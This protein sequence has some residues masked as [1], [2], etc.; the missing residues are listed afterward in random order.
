MNVLPETI[1]EGHASRYEPDDLSIGHASR[2]EPLISNESLSNIMNM[3]AETIF[4]GYAS[5][6]GPRRQIKKY[7]TERKSR[8]NK[9][10]R[11]IRLMKA[12]MKVHEENCDS[13]DLMLKINKKQ[14]SI[15]NPSYL[16]MCVL[17]EGFSI[18]IYI[19]TYD[20]EMWNG[21]VHMKHAVRLILEKGMVAMCHESLDHFGTK[22]R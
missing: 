2:Q 4:D 9:N 13:N 5:R 20:T 22:S 15:P 6:H 3:L 18:I 14:E 7:Q 17:E 8:K 12:V 16:M 11:V 10:M 1:F 19:C 21:C